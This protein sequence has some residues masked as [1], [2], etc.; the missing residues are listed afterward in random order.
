MI[1]ESIEDGDLEAMLTADE[2]AVAF[3]RN[4]YQ[5]PKVQVNLRKL[6]PFYDQLGLFDWAFISLQRSQTLTLLK[7][8]TFKRGIQ[9]CRIGPVPFP[10]S[11]MK[12]NNK[13]KPIPTI[14]W[15]CFCFHHIFLLNWRNSYQR[16]NLNPFIGFIHDHRPF[17]GQLFNN[18]NYY[19]YC[20]GVC[21]RKTSSSAIKKQIWFSESNVSQ[22][23]QKLLLKTRFAVFF[24]R[25]SPFYKFPVIFGWQELKMDWK[26]KRR[27][28]SSLSICFMP[29]SSRLSCTLR[30]WKIIFSLFQCFQ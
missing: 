6:I 16:W 12:L 19:F 22:L 4:M 17:S 10:F 3:R 24:S 11:G 30:E 1:N 18:S 20:Y 21:S 8:V 5:Q 2:R 29:L 28:E 7:R 14:I 26:R 25:F 9:L 15:L 27:N 23:R 13:S